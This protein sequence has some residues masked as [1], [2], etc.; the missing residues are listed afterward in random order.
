MICLPERNILYPSLATSDSVPFLPLTQLFLTE[1]KVQ[2]PK[3]SCCLFALLI[4][5]V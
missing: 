2:F 1:T 5:N 3:V 4:Y